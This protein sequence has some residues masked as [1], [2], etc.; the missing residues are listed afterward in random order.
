VCLC[1]CVCV[2][3]CVLGMEEKHEIGRCIS[4]RWLYNKLSLKYNDLELLNCF[5]ESEIWLSLGWV[6]RIP[7]KALVKVSTRA[8][9]AHDLHGYAA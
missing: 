1:V 2:C 9:V 3:V 6:F 7:H 5:Y 4:Y 8:V